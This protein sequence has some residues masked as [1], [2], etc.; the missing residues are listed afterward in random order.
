MFDCNIHMPCSKD[1]LDGRLHDEGVMLGGD[2]MH[3]F[4][5]HLT[6]LKNYIESGNFMLFNTGLDY[7]DMS[8]FV[9]HVCKVFADACFTILADL[10]AKQPIEHVHALKKSGVVAIKFHCYFQRISEDQYPK[11]LQLAT[12]ASML[13][14]PIFIDTSYGSIDMYRYDNLKLAAFLLREIKSVPVVL[15]H[16]GGARAMEAFLL[17]DACPNVF[18]DTSFSVP[19]YM[20][21]TIEKDLAFAYKRI[22]VERVLFGSDFPY[23]NF[24]DALTKTRLFF[25][26]NG[27][28]D[29]EIEIVFSNTPQKVFGRL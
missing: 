29:S 24:E 25:E 28:S 4:D 19:Y 8:S 26:R 23:I 18:L 22:G 14:M 12:A 21:S 6:D 1:T 10:N 3:C 5:V 7:S 9:S 11:V 16:S 15:L 27:F 2:L 20:D 13:N 17:A